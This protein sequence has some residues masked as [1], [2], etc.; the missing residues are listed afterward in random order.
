MDGV[1]PIGLF[2]GSAIRVL[3]TK[4]KSLFGKNSQVGTN[5]G[6]I[7]LKFNLC[8]FGF[9]WPYAGFK[10]LI[11]SKNIASKLAENQNSQVGTN[12]G[13]IKA[14]FIQGFHAPVE[15]FD[16][17][18]KKPCPTTFPRPD[19]DKGVVV[20]AKVHIVKMLKM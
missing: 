20:V 18:V 17:L 7:F 11:K 8:C 14:S 1:D 4:L 15:H 13:K 19:I 5:L 2:F 10:I 16:E 6:T 9:V 12:L 3:A